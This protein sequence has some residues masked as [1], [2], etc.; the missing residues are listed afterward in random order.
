MI[1]PLHLIS[2]EEGYAQMRAI[3]ADIYLARNITLDNKKILDS[4]KKV[5]ILMSG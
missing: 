5:D 2:K 1:Y 3:L 4:L